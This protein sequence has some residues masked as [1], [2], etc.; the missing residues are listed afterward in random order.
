[1][2][3]VNGGWRHTAAVTSEG[4]LYTWGWNR[5]GQLGLGHLDDVCEPSEVTSFSRADAAIALV[6]CGWRHTIAV[7]ADGA[8]YSWGRGVNGQLGHG[9]NLDV[10]APPLAALPRERPRG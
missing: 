1:M 7:T 3:Q 6:T 8:V 2:V 4:H 9:A 10:Y 5:F